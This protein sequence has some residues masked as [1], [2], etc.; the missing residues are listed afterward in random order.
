MRSAYELPFFGILEMNC[1]FH[2]PRYSTVASAVETKK[3]NESDVLNGCGA[4]GAQ[5]PLC[6]ADELV[7]LNERLVFIDTYSVTVALVREHVRMG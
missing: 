6:G 7:K 1:A 3:K 2:G 4:Q 5:C